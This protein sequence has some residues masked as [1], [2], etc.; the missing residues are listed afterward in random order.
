MQHNI[1]Y[2]SMTLRHISDTLE[3][4]G[5]CFGASQPWFLSRDDTK[6]MQFFKTSSL[7]INT[8]GQL[9]NIIISIKYI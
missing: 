5:P 1:Q 4:F 9:I 3:L 7:I 2:K 8:Y 6:P